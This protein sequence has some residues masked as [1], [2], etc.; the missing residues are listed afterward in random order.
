M[1][2]ARVAISLAL[3]ALFA[4]PAE[5][6]PLETGLFDQTAF[7]AEDGSAAMVR[8]RAAGA[9]SVRLVLYWSRVAPGGPEKPAGFDPSSPVDPGYDWS[10]FDRLVT[11]AADHGLEPI[12][13]VF[14]APLWAERSHGKQGGSGVR[15]PDP[16]ELASFAKA[17]A[18]RYSGAIPGLPRV[19]RWQLWNEPNLHRFLWPQFDVPASR[20]VPKDADALSPEYYRRMVRAFARAVHR[21]HA[22]NLVVVGGLAPFGNAHGG[23]HAVP[24][25]QFM[26]ELLCL[27][28]KNRP[29]RDCKPLP[30]DVW[31]HHPYTEGGPDHRAAVPG[32]ASLG[33]LPAMRRILDAAVRAGRISSRRR[34]AFWV[35]EFSW[36]TKPPDPDG[37]PA[38]LHARWVAE[39]LYRMWQQ[40]VSLVIWF[41]V[42]DDG[43]RGGDQLYHQSGLYFHCAAGWSCSEPKRSFTA[44]RFPF[45]AFRAGGRVR[46]W[47][48]TPSSSSGDVIV[49]QR[50]RRGGWRR[51]RR[52]RAG[53][54]GIFSA[55]PRTR[56]KGA[57]RARIPTARAASGRGERS[58]PFK[59][60]KTP[61]VPVRVFG[62]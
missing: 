59:L 3:T 1:L 47:G 36:D 38:K 50:R 23:E 58:L 40:R 39:A 8:T 46:V 61:D 25:L 18:R 4:V 5:A 62:D 52:L 41:K 34:V 13:T 30:F 11:E 9:T 21:V 54:H 56:A 37:V 24:P 26:R 28:A 7:E 22:G 20:R 31:S 42:R 16:A 51:V 6:R 10:Y 2:R 19:R 14:L 15:K 55:R 49:E 27:G 57:L 35:T 43:Q 44:F 12:V 45:V 60:M 48:R 32:N 33:D 29:T 17:A 53:R